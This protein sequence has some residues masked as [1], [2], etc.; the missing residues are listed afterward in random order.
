[1]S[2]EEEA[3]FLG[4]K[5]RYPRSAADGI[6]GLTR[7]Q[8]KAIAGAGFGVG[9]HTSNHSRLDEL[10][11][12][13]E[14]RREIVED[15]RTLE[16]I[17]GRPVKYFAYPAGRFVHPAFDPAALVRDAGYEA[18]VTT[19]PGINDSGTD[20]YRL[21]RELT[22]TYMSPVVFRARV[23]GCYDPIRSLKRRLRRA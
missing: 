21:R 1:M 4:A 7:E 12:A 17:T 3:A 13:A 22:G 14:A 23:C 6:R 18:A 9:G 16:G 5:L 19:Q 15:K 8:V 11:D 20:R 10:G 2:G